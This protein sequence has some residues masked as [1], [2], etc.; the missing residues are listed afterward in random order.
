MTGDPFL[1]LVALLIMGVP[2]FI[3]L[4]KFIRS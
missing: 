4:R 3:I 1:A 2:A